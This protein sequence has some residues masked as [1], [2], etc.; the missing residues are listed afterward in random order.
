MQITVARLINFSLE[1]SIKRK[2]NEFYFEMNDT[3]K[4]KIFISAVFILNREKMKIE[5]YL[6]WKILQKSSFVYLL[7][8]DI[9]RKTK[10][11]SCYK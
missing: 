10:I 7:G 5:I 9:L 6:F 3:I 1:N 8:F 4:S 2:Q 11:K